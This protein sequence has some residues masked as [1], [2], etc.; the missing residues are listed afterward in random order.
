[1]ILS[2]PSQMDLHLVLSFYRFRCRLH[3]ITRGTLSITPPFTHTPRTESCWGCAIIPLAI[4][5]NFNMLVRPKQSCFC[6][7]CVN[8]T[9]PH[10]ICGYRDMTC[11]IIIVP[12]SLHLHPPPIY[13]YFRGLTESDTFETHEFLTYMTLHILYIT[14]NRLNI[15]Q[16]PSVLRQS[17]YDVVVT[18]P[19]SPIFP[20][21][22]RALGLRYIVGT[23][24]D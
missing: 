23:S 16:L 18:V 17:E 8:S 9:T 4:V 13:Q 10:R 2:F 3:S 15:T 1:M 20:C 12:H 5:T 19:T 14:K 6:P 7:R 21:L 22:T 11:A 24:Y